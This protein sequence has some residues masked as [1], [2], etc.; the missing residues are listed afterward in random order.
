MTPAQFMKFASV[1][2]ETLAYFES[3]HSIILKWQAKINLISAATVESIYERHFADSAQIFDLLS[4]DDKVVVD[5]GSGAGFPGLVLALMARDQGRSTTF[6][7]VE[8]DTRKAAF[9]IDAAR[10]VGLLGK[11]IRIHPVRAERLGT[12]DLAG[13][14]DCVTARALTAL[15]DLLGYAAPFLTPSGRCLFLKGAKADEELAAARAAGWTFTVTS[16]P[17]R[18]PGDGVILEIHSLVRAPVLAG[19]APRK[20]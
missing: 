14:A 16:T 2:R 7:L 20:L 10:E 17:N 12:T 3:Y 9:L 15:P 13:Q 5:L 1:S 4:I 6:H 19:A 8:S 18:L 11:T